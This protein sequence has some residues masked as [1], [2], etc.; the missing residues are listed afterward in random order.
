MLDISRAAGLAIALS[1]PVAASALTWTEEMPFGDHSLAA[2]TDSSRSHDPLLDAFV[3]APSLVLSNRDGR[4]PERLCL[5]FQPAE[6]SYVP[7]TWAVATPAPAIAAGEEAARSP[8]N[9]GGQLTTTA[10]AIALG[11]LGLVALPCAYVAW[12]VVPGASGGRRGRYASA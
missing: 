8:L 6:T 10:L 4:C 7:S 5:L 1:F 12:R 3:D 2:T 9:S 11:V